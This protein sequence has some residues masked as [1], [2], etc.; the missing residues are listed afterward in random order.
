VSVRRFTG[1]RPLMRLAL[2]FLML[3][4]VAG[5]AGPSG[6]GERVFAR[7]ECG[8]T[9]ASI[10]ELVGASFQKQGG[11]SPDG[12]THTIIT[13]DWIGRSTYI[14]LAIP[15]GKLASARICWDYKMTAVACAT[16]PR[17]DC[18]PWRPNN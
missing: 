11:P 17:L 8:M 16:A 10:S 2:P 13:Q 1:V 5:C 18:E 12:T 3:L 4:C 14:H 6:S 7:L 9:E 15:S